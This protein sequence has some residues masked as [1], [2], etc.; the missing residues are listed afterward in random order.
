M[1]IGGGPGEHHRLLPTAFASPFKRT[2]TRRLRHRGPSPFTGRPSWGRADI[3]P[4][5]YKR[6]SA[7]QPLGEAVAGKAHAN[8]AALPERLRLL[9]S[10]CLGHVEISYQGARLMRGD[11]PPG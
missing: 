10:R 5:R 9:S 8:T 3:S 6:C 7:A 2:A 11:V 1:D 4:S